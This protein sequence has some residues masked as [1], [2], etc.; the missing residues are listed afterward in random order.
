[1]VTVAMRTRG[2]L[3]VTQ[4][5]L[6]GMAGEVRKGLD[7]EGSVLVKG[8]LWRARAVDGGPIAAGSRVRVRD[9]DGIILRVSH[10]PAPAPAE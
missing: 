1:M 7:P 5:G 10:E 2:K 6:I 8:V 9:V 4:R 3:A